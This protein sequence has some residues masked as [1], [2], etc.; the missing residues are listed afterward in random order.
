MICSVR[1]RFKPIMRALKALLPES[2]DR[3]EAALICM[4]MEDDDE[5]LPKARK[6]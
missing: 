5:V 3:G 1:E 2:I 6:K 4:R